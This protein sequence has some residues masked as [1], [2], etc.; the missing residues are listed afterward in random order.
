MMQ[1]KKNKVFT[2]IGF[3]MHFGNLAVAMVSKVRNAALISL[4][5]IS[6]I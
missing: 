1:K 4:I 3:F 6:I 2:L 5:C